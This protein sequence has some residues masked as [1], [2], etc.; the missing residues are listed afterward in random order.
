M[1]ERHLPSGSKHGLRAEG[2]V[3]TVMTMTEPPRARDSVEDEAI[4]RER[5]H[6]L[7]H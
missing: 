5:E 6:M 7:P 2:E 1:L 4:K 3:T